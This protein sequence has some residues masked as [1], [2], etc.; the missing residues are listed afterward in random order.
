MNL[1]HQAIYFRHNIMGLRSCARVVLGGETSPLDS[2]RESFRARAEVLLAVALVEYHPELDTPTGVFLESALLLQRAHR[3]PVFW[4][5][6]ATLAAGAT[7]VTSKLG[8][9][10]AGKKNLTYRFLDERGLP[11]AR[12][13]RCWQRKKSAIRWCSNPC[14]PIGAGG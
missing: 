11:V 13:R 5:R 7:V 4:S 8:R 2:R 9:K 6:S 10:L 12:R 14:A 3:Y 1:L